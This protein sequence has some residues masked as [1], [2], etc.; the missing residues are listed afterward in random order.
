MTKRCKE[1]KLAN[2]SYQEA[3]PTCIIGCVRC[4][5]AK[6]GGNIWILCNVSVPDTPSS[7]HDCHP[8]VINS[9][10][11]LLYR[12][13]SQDTDATVVCPHHLRLLVHHSQHHDVRPLYWKHHQCQDRLC[14]P[15]VKGSVR[16]PTRLF[17]RLRSGGGWSQLFPSA[18]AAS[19]LRWLPWPW[20]CGRSQPLASRR[21][22]LF[23]FRILSVF[24]KKVRR[25]R[26]LA[27]K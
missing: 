19:G 2:I 3:Y 27:A 7:F 25:W 4:P 12:H 9:A 11:P 23:C 15:Q 1:L 16:S 20:R 8:G 14:S 5:I 17:L 10:I 22:S 13:C 21:T 26:H 24:F 18:G 6:I